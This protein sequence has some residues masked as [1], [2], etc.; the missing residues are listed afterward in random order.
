MSTSLLLF[1]KRFQSMTSALDDALYHQT[2]TPIGF[3]YR[4]RLNPRF[5]IQP[6]ETLSRKMT[7]YFMCVR[8][9]LAD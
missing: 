4:R 3:L 2:K 8:D 5:L 7:I 6:S 9:I 1:L